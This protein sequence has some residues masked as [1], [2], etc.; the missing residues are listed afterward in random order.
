MS[1]LQLNKDTAFD[2]QIGPERQSKRMSAI[3]PANFDLRLDEK[4]AFLQFDFQ[5]RFVS[6][7]QKPRPEFTMDKNR[8]VE[9]RLA[10]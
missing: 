4:T 9:N 8:R 5:R 6:R 7:F 2:E 1:R 3:V 10:D